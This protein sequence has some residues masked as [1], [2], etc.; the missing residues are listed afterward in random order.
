MNSGL[1]MGSLGDKKKEKGVFLNLCLLSIEV[2]DLIQS[3]VAYVSGVQP[4]RMDA[5][6]GVLASRLGPK[7]AKVIEELFHCF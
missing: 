5:M 7:A 6:K 1:I 4:L 2:L 3:R